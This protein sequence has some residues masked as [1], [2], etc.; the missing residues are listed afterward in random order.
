MRRHLDEA[1]EKIIL[2]EAGKTPAKEIAALLE[3]PVDAIYAFGRRKGIKFT[4]PRPVRN[5]VHTPR[6]VKEKEVPFERAPAVYNNIP[7]P[8]GVADEL[9][10]IRLA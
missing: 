8:Y 6:K 1:D 7:S 2:F 5:Y 3:L 10:G 4:I 9:R